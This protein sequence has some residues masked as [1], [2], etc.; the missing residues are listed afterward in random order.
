MYSHAKRRKLEQRCYVKFFVAGRFRIGLYSH[1]TYSI[2]LARYNVQK[3]II[4]V[5]FYSG[6]AVTQSEICKHQSV[7]LTLALLKILF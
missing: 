7:V 3:T 1:M 6:T 2:F 5:A 4:S